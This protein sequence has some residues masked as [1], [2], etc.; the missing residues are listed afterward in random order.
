MGYVVAAWAP[1][2]D[3][4]NGILPGYVMGLFFFT[5]YPLRLPV[6]RSVRGEANAVRP[7]HR[8]VPAWQ[9]SSVPWQHASSGANVPSHAGM[10][11]PFQL[12]RWKAP[13]KRRSMRAQNLPV[14]IGW[15]HYLDFLHYAWAALMLNE[16]EDSTEVFLGNQTVRQSLVA[17]GLRHWQ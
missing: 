16:F 5:G 13:V 17:Q 14:W 12:L 3:V 11:R 8:S 7:E 15:F 6:C 2:L 4:A 1:D 10:H 9:M